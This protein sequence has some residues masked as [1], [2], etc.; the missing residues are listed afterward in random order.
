MT[1]SERTIRDFLYLD[2]DR[3]Y[4]L[5]SQVFEGVAGQMIESFTSQAATT[6]SGK[7]RP[8]SGR[9]LEDQI[10][11]LS[12]RTQVKWL[13][14]HMYSTL[15]ERLRGVTIENPKVTVKD[16]E[17]TLAGCFLLKVAGAAEIADFHACEL[18]S[19]NSTSLGKR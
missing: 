7:A 5:Y 18:F 1:K 3:M 8:F 6:E 19:K 11:E 12:N 9:T 16:Y 10:V 14:D 15:E 2:L 4:S 17:R 13:H